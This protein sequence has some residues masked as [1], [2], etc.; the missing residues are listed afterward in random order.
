MQVKKTVSLDKDTI[1]ILKKYS[2]VVIGAENISASIR[3][4]AR[5]AEVSEAI[6]GK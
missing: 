6:N 1:D 4:L 5:L 3:L 2:I